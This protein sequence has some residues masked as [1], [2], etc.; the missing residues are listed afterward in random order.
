MDLKD[1]LT[2]EKLSKKFK[3]QF[4]LV[5]YA[6]Q[7]AANMI[8]SGR[9]SRI[10]TDIQNRA[11]MVLNEILND[12]D[13]FDEIVTEIIESHMSQVN[14]KESTHVFGSAKSSERKKSR[15]AL[16]D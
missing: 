3:S 16:A 9:E 7:L 8:H 12:K 11:M 14:G 15:R 2:N 4:E 5:N 1:S 10:K 6:I 13:Q